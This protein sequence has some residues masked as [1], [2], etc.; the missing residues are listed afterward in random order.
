ML[1]GLRRFGRLPWARRLLLVRAFALVAAMRVALKALPFR[2]VAEGVRR[3]GAGTARPD[4]DV[5]A[6]AHAVDAVSRRLLRDRPCLTQ[7]LA[8]W[9][10]ARRRGYPSDLRIGVRKTPDGRVEAHAWIEQDGRI[11]IG[12]LPDLD[13][14]SVLPPIAPLR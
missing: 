12:W 4:H 3:L 10:F 5:H 11:L 14:F 2:R 7:A 6:Y 9:V 13:T 8:L 1:R